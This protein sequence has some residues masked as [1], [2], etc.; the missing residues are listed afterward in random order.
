LDLILIVF[1]FFLLSVIHFIS[2]L[3]CFQWDSN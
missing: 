3:S 1:F 2:Y